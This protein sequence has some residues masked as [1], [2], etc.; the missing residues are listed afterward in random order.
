MKFLS[1][2]FNLLSK[3][4]TIVAVLILLQF[5]F[6]AATLQVFSDYYYY[7]NAKIGRAHV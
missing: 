5:L 3:R 7:V 1:K 2:L 4:L 6:I